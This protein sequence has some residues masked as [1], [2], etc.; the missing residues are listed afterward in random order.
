VSV[1]GV[2][3][4]TTSSFNSIIDIQSGLDYVQAMVGRFAFISLQLKRIPTITHHN[5]K[6]QTHYTIQLTLPDDF[7]LQALADL[8]ADNE[9]I[10]TQAQYQLPAPV[11]ENPELDPP[12]EII[13]EEDVPPPP[14]DPPPDEMPDISE[15]ATGP[16]YKK[17]YAM[18]KEATLDDDD[19]ELFKDFVK[20]KKGVE[21]ITKD[22]M[23]KIFDNFEMTCEAFWKWEKRQGETQQR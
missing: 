13:D 1:A 23:S 5:E 17:L 2:Y 10:Y 22:I 14:P 18:L 12:D 3:Q 15:R 4:I 6:R 8:K 11:D 7:N 19:I 20:Q 16:Q 21:V 9:R